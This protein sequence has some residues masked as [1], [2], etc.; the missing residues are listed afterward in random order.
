M[1]SAGPSLLLMSLLMGLNSAA[2][3]VGD[4]RGSAGRWL[5]G[6]DMIA[7][8]PHMGSLVILAFS[9]EMCVQILCLIFKLGYFYY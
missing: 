9:G 8:P 4:H 2:L 6:M 5:S 1:G 3:L 7:E